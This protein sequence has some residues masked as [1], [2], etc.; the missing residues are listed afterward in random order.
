M[1]FSWETTSVLSLRIITKGKQ[2]K[3]LVRFALILY[4]DYLIK[5][6]TKVVGGN[7]KKYFVIQPSNW[8]TESICI[9]KQTYIIRIYLLGDMI[10]RRQKTQKFSTT[11]LHLNIVLTHHSHQ[12]PL[13]PS[14]PSKEPTSGLTKFQH[15]EHICCHAS[16]HQGHELGHSLVYNKVFH[17][18]LG[19]HILYKIPA[20]R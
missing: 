19:F 7:N 6:L 5:R 3:V 16:C 11:K 15:T 4:Y 9:W 14:R 2:R 18:S 8:K 13:Y 17:S 12:S 20:K 1:K 10:C